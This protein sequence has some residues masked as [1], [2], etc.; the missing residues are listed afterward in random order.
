MNKIE[1]IIGMKRKGWPEKMIKVF[2]R[3]GLTCQYCGMNGLKDREYYAHLTIDH[4]IPLNLGGKDDEENLVVACGQCNRLKGFRLPKEIR[5]KIN[6]NVA[7]QEILAEIKEWMNS[8]RKRD[9]I[10]FEEWKKLFEEMRKEMREI[11][12]QMVRSASKHDPELITSLSNELY[13]KSGGNMQLLH[14]V[15]S[16]VAPS[17]PGPFDLPAQWLYREITEIEKQHTNSLKK[18]TGTAI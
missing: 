2:I 8:K 6:K 15:F 9:D 16:S 1:F 12:L 5:E 17:I 11:M 7:P 3:D 14:S 13:E 18:A 4:I 10:S